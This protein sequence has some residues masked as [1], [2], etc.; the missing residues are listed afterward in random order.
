VRIFVPLLGA[1]LAL[2]SAACDAAPTTSGAGRRE[3]PA[4]RSFDPPEILGRLRDER[5]T[6]ASGIVAARRTPG[7]FWVHNDSGSAPELFCVDERARTCGAVTISAAHAFDWEDIAA[8]PDGALYVGDIGDNL[9]DRPSVLV[10]VVRERT[11][12]GAKAVE[13]WPVARRLEF[14]YPTGP[15]DAEALSVHPRS[16]AVYVI[17]KDSPA[18]VLRGPPNGGV[19]EVVGALRLPGLLSLPTGADISPD[20]RRVVV[21][22]YDDAFEFSLPHDRRFDAIWKTEPRA[23]TLPLASQREAIAYGANGEAIV[24]T[25]EGRNQPLIRRR[26]AQ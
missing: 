3:G 24:T 7:A 2:L 22:T 25:S 5:I 13:A 19:M 4:E 1:L 9:E 15:L 11:A 14:T 16:G 18:V 26:I 23:V 6:E 8:G 17:T 12:P 21:A 20:G 10:Y